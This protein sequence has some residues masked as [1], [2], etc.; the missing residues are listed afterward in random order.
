METGPILGS[1]YWT[2]IGQWILDPSWAVD[3]RPILGSENWIH[4]GQWILDPFWA[5]DTMSNTVLKF[6]DF[7]VMQILRKINFG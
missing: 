7:S 5:V 2:Q 3:T 1:G 4:F 6:Q